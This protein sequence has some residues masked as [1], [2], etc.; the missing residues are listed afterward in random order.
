MVR[1][2]LCMTTVCRRSPANYS[3]TEIF[4]VWKCWP[5]LVVLRYGPFRTPIWPISRSNMAYIGSQ[6]DPFC[7]LL[8]A[9]VLRRAV[10]A[11][12]GG[13]KNHVEE[14][15]RRY[16]GMHIYAEMDSVYAG[17]A[18]GAVTAGQRRNT[19]SLSGSGHRRRSACGPEAGTAAPWACRCRFRASA[20]SCVCSAP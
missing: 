18:R 1:L 6:N 12:P 10:F 14:S 9:N 13:G 5:C 19:P 20:Q 15:F 11:C 16:G 3:E 4:A 8:N 2:R 17:R 7:N